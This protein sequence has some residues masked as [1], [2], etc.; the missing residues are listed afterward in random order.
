MAKN[1]KKIPHILAQGSMWK[2]RVLGL[3]NKTHEVEIKSSPCHRHNSV[4]ENEVNL[5]LTEMVEDTRGSR[6]VDGRDD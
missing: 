6:W 4:T 1:D 5:K 2:C 3:W